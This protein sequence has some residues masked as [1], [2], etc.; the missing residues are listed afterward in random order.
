MPIALAF[1][2]LSNLQFVREL[3]HRL[4]LWRV[5]PLLAPFRGSSRDSLAGFLVGRFRLGVCRLLR[6]F[7][8]RLLRCFGF[9]RDEQ[10]LRLDQMIDLT[11][12]R[13]VNMTCEGQPKGECGKLVVLC[14]CLAGP[15]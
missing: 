1:H 5:G 3:Q 10:F 12:A 4:L 15:F 6:G 7:G 8:G 11:L 2:S 14:G 13:N 9:H